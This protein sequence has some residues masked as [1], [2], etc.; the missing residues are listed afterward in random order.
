MALAV[1]ALVAV[2]A[3]VGLTVV[4][5]RQSRHERRIAHIENEVG[6]TDV[7]R[8]HAE[9]VTLPG[10][11]IPGT[12]IRSRLDLGERKTQRIDRRLGRLSRSSSR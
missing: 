1:V 7:E 4:W 12:T 5:Q 8:S 6:V 9:E 2:A 3:L 11:K 10:K